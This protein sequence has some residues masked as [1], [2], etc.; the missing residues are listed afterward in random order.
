[1]IPHFENDF[2]KILFQAFHDLYPSA[3]VEVW[4]ALS[5]E[6][7]GAMGICSWTKSGPIVAID[8][9]LPAFNTVDI[10]CHELAHAA[11]CK[12]CPDEPNHHCEDWK[13]AYDAI[14]N[15]YCEITDENGKSKMVELFKEER[16]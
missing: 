12:D 16:E 2:H 14:Y 11:T 1:M 13:K 9:G 15:R 8:V 3:K 10:L 4:W 5:E 7:G 6:I